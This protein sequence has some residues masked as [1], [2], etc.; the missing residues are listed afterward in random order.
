[1]LRG[2]GKPRVSQ[3]PFKIAV[4]GCDMAGSTGWTVGADL[5]FE[6]LWAVTA[7]VVFVPVSPHQGTFMV[8]ETLNKNECV[9]NLSPVG[10][11]LK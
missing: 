8:H 2:R 4:G 5:N 11:F 6:D 7:H 9:S 1:M 10:P 3:Q